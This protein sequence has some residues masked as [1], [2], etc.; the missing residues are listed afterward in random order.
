MGFMVFSIFSTS[1][2]GHTSISNATRLFFEATFAFMNIEP[3]LHLPNCD[4]R[5]SLDTVY[6]KILQTHS[7]DVGIFMAVASKNKRDAAVRY[8]YDL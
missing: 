5:F 4:I 1:H 7:V 3:H 8:W 6:E 2:T